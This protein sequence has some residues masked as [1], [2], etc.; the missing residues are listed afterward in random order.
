MFLSFLITPYS[1]L[2]LPFIFYLL[3]YVRSHA[4]R[5][6]PGPLPAAFSNLWLLYQCRCGRRF[7]AVDAAHKKYGKLVRIQPNHMS[8][9]DNEAISVIYSHGGGWLKRYDIIDNHFPQLAPLNIR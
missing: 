4:V 2:L 9:A 1:L 3:P 6:V 7:A 5:N 8:I